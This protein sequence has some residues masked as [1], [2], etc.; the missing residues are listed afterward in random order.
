MAANLLSTAANLSLNLQH[1]FG[2][3]V[4]ISLIHLFYL[5]YEDLYLGI[6]NKR[7]RLEIR[8]E[9]LHREQ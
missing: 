2:Y 5:S 9:A 8:N 7:L 1:I 4:C 6:V 3:I